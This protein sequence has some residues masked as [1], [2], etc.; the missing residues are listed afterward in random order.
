MRMSTPKYFILGIAVAAGLAFA[1]PMANAMN[2]SN[3]EK[4]AAG[5]AADPDFAAG[6]A[7]VDAKDWAKAIDFLGKA[8]AK[9]AKNADLENYFGY[10]L[11][12]AGNMDEALKHYTLALK[13]NPDHKGAHEY[14]GEAYLL[15]G[16]LKNA[17]VHLDALDKLCLFGCAEYPALK[18]KVA[19]Y[20]KSKTS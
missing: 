6:K 8:E 15:K 17:E 13:I 14:M 4:P 19:E 2:S 3:D 16:D 18:Q 7:A 1:A 12:N 9:D 20:K 5:K 10:A 11:R